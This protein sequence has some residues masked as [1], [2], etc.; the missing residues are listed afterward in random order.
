M[1]VCQRAVLLV[2]CALAGVA[3]GLGGYLVTGSQW[4][5]TALPAVLAAAWLGVADP[6]R[7][8]GGN[9]QRPAPGPRE[10]ALDPAHGDRS[11]R[12]S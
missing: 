6:E 8:V 7:C 11:C 1:T 10:D 2:V 4:W 5:F 3:V 12:R 9:A